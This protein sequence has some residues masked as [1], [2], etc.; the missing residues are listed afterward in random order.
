MIRPIALVALALLLGACPGE[1]PGRSQDHGISLVDG[2]QPGID[3]PGKTGDRAG[4]PEASAKLDGKPRADT[5]A[6]TPDQKQV[7]P[8]AWTGTDDIGKPC[9]GNGDCQFNWCAENTHTGVK[10]CTKAC[11]PCATT[12]CPTGSG[13][14]NAGIAYICAPGYPNAP[15]P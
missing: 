14:Q 1:N 4:S 13:C 11:D 12:P 10:F 6:K 7:Q 2:Q 5:K 15:C 3:G 9:Q 8:D